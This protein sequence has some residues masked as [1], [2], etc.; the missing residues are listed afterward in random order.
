MPYLSGMFLI[1][2]IILTGL[3]YMATNKGGTKPTR[4]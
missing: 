4:E 3:G 1:I 2:N